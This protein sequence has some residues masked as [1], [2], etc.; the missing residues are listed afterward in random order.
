MSE[1]DPGHVI[2]I[3]SD[4]AFQILS[5]GRRRQILLSLDESNGVLTASNLAVEIAAVEAGINPNQVTGEQRMRVYVSLI[6]SHL[7]ILD[8]LGVADYDARAKRVSPTNATEP[9]ARHI[10]KLKSACYELEDGDD[11]E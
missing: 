5:N 6:Q 3:D 7:R 9:I 1:T 11:A 4:D 2:P 10:R 8:E